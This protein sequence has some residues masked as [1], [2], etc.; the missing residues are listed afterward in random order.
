MTKVYLAANPSHLEAVNPVLEGIVRAKQD[1]LDLAGEAFTVLPDA[2]AR[3]RGLRRPGRRGR[4]AEPLAAARLP[5]RRHHPRGDQQPG[6]LHHLAVVVALVVLLHR[7]RP[8]DPGAGLPRE[9]RRPRGVRPGG[10]AGLRVPPAVQQ[11]R[12]HRH[13]LL[14]PPRSQRGRRPLDD[15]AADVQPDRGQALGP[16]ALHRARSSAAATSASR[17]PRRR[18]GTTSSS[19][20]AC[21]PRPSEAIKGQAPDTTL[22]ATSPAPTSE[23][24][25]G[26][27]RPAAQ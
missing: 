7:R 14:P 25:G 9:R 24:H 10:R 19:S 18:C 3:R 1:R 22:P 23:G 8:D 11:G 21:S 27:E 26:L 6:R 12:H 20:S 5:H 2:H 17:R 13:G 15:P 16:Q 4:D